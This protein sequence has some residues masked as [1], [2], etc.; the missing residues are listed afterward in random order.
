MDK[1]VFIAHRGLSSQALENTLPA[2]RLAAKHQF[3]AIETDIHLSRDGVFVIHHD[4]DLSRIYNQPLKLVDE[5]YDSLRQASQCFGNRYRIAKLSDFL[6][7]CRKH[8]I[9]AVVEL[10]VLFS[11]KE[12]EKL[13]Q[14]TKKSLHFI[15]F[16]SFYLENLYLLRDLGYEGPMQILSFQPIDE[17]LYF[18]A[19]SLHADVD[20][21]HNLA[22]PEVIEKMHE[23]GILVNV[24]TVDDK[25]KAMT[26]WRHGVDFITTNT[27]AASDF[28]DA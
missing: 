27:F 11:K 8:N 1:P 14:K 25:E 19:Q 3:T 5:N 21:H 16:I 10:K 23:L 17:T 4:E 24:W 12:I 15:I 9:T 26:L 6:S 28:D 18:H 20:I 22:T 2:F 7:I 13:L